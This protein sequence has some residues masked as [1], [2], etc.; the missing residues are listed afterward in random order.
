MNKQI[1]STIIGICSSLVLTCIL[2]LHNVHANE[3]PNPQVIIEEAA[4]DIPDK[5]VQQI[6]QENPD[7]GLITIYEYTKA[8]PKI[9]ESKN[10]NDVILP[11][12][13]N[14]IF[15][16]ITTTISNQKYDQELHDERILSVAKGQ[17]KTLETTLTFSFK[18]SI[19][20]STLKKSDINAEVT[21]SGTFKEG[22]TYDGPPE[23]SP[24]NSRE[25]RI[26]FLGETGN[27]TQTQLVTTYLTGQIISQKVLSEEGTYE[28]PTDSIS[29]SVDRY[30]S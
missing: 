26:K 11:H 15:G 19:K 29:Y 5:F 21:I 3:E 17:K 30:I 20:G 13:A 23:G 28:K 4:S 2:P 18:G 9:T 25:Y 27:Y 7:A 12:L 1:I 6:I 8:E 22:D 24:F 14:T 16:P 10:D